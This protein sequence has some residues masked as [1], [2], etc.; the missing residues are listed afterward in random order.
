[1]SVSSANCL[2][3]VSQPNELQGPISCSWYF[4]Q[5]HINLPQDGYDFE[6]IPQDGYDF[7]KIYLKMGMVFDKVIGTWVCCFQKSV[8][9]KNR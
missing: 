3:V 7:E 2:K 9:P 8:F 5:S 6:N 1:M 4:L